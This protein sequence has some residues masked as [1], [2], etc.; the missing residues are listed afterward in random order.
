MIINELDYISKWCFK[1]GNANNVMANC[2]ENMQLTN[3]L[4]IMF[5]AVMFITRAS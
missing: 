3:G 4:I 2:L 5:I 1:H